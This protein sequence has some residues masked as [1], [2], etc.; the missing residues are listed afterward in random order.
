[1]FAT[2]IEDG[3]RPGNPIAG[4]GVPAAS[5]DGEPAEEKVKALTRAELGE[6]PGRDPRGPAGLLR[7]PDPYR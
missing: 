3:L 6:A 4:V 7:V 5:E 1:M 2:A